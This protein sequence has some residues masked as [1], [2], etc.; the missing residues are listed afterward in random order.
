VDHDFEAVG[1]LARLFGEAQ[2]DQAR[3][4]GGGQVCAIERDAPCGAGLAVG[5]VAIGSGHQ[6]TRISSMRKSILRACPV[7]IRADP[8]WVTLDGEG[9]QHRAGAVHQRP[10]LALVGHFGQRLDGRGAA[11]QFGHEGA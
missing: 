6:A 1:F 2:R 3:G 5:E 4:K 8:P 11:R 10:G 7:S 9:A